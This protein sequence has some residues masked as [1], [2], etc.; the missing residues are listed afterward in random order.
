M[1]QS[2]KTKSQDSL[3]RD[4]VSRACY[5][6]RR[7]AE[8]ATRLERA[9]LRAGNDAALVEA[10]LMRRCAA[11]EN[12]WTATELQSKHGELYEGH[13]TLWNCNGRLCPSC[14]AGRRRRMR[15]HV[16]A[17]VARVMPM[18]G[19]NWRL[20][21][22]TA[23]PL[24]GVPLLEVRE[25]FNRAWVLLRKREWWQG[26]VRAGVKGEEFTLGDV[27]R[28]EREGR[29]WSLERDGYHF[30][31]HLLVC[32]RWIEWAALGEEWT[33]CLMKAASERGI[34]LEFGTAHGRAV[35]DVRLVVNRQTRTR[36]T[37]GV[38]GAV[39]EVSKYITKSESWLQL[40]EAQLLE[41]ASVARWFRAVELLGDCR[42]ERTEAERAEMRE[43][44]Q[45]REREK[46]LRAEL[47]RRREAVT[48]AERLAALEESP[49][50]VTERRWLVEAGKLVERDEVVEDD[51]A[52]AR[53]VREALSW[54][55]LPAGLRGA[56]RR[57]TP[58]LD[59]KNLSDGTPEGRTAEIGA[60]RARGKPL[61][62]S[63]REVDRQTWLESLD[64][65]VRQA[66]EWRRS[67]LVWRFPLATFRT[68]AGARWYGLRANPASSMS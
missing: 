61:R 47:L 7:G 12:L 25:V 67:E 36:G 16:R 35:V 49:E 21:T 13:G 34:A 52:L 32:S 19:E 46:A 51:R 66:R 56:L 9:A 38:D 45:S 31:I 48:D 15:A 68:L 29:A 30:H 42:Q 37:V 11:L 22:L 40:P 59:T 53:E 18:P 10:E 23:P 63:A 3:R 60:M 64:E 33:A 1:T 57:R 27:R 24:V 8:I 44:R 4:T 41:V 28:L 55:E 26:R 2:L 54:G 20:V 65:Q 58:Y 5:R 6:A 62:A 50:E 39:E 17:G 43:R 14:L